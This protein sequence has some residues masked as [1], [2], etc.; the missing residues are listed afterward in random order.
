MADEPDKKTKAYWQGRAE[1]FEEELTRLRAESK[2]AEQKRLEEEAA[3]G[4]QGVDIDKIFDTVVEGVEQMI[5]QAKT[6]KPMIETWL[7][8]R[9]TKE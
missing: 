9:T 6:Y 8:N 5:A 7:K 4:E 2:R 3:A 1:V